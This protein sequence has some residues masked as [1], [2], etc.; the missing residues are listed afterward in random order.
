MSRNVSTLFAQEFLRLDYCC[1]HLVFCAKGC[2][3][4]TPSFVAFSDT[5][6]NCCFFFPLSLR[7]Y[8]LPSCR[9]LLSCYLPA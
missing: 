4:H 7:A 2:K 9:F 8:E 1:S 5:Q 6:V 3:K